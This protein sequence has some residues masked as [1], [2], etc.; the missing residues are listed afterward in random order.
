MEEEELEEIESEDEEETEEA[1]EVEKEIKLT[2]K[3]RVWIR[4][5]M[6]DGN[7]TRAALVAY[8]PDHLEILN[9]EYKF[10]TDEQK[11]IYSNA[12]FIG[13][14]NQKKLKIPI[15]DLMDESGM[16]DA[17]LMLKLKENLNATKLYGKDSVEGMDGIARTK[18]FETAVKMR[19]Q[20]VDRVD[21]T[22]K[23]RRIMQPKIVSDIRPDLDDTKAETTTSNT[24]DQE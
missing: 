24:S 8:Y 7:Q 12:G 13:W 3:Q 17:Y 18:A 14:E 4:E 22:S 10:L 6:E 19:G 21:H 2:F 9:I 11:K 15:R 1:P 16:G 20:L 5:Y 23:G